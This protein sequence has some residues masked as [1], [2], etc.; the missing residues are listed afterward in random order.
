MAREEIGTYP[1][2]TKGKIGSACAHFESVIWLK[3]YRMCMCVL[4]CMWLVL[5]Y[6]EIF[7]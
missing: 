6:P 5:F 4:V 3:A 1:Q 2:N 7:E